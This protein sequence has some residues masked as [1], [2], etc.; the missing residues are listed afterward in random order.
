MAPMLIKR[1]GGHFVN[2]ASAGGLIPWPGA[3]C[4]ATSKYAVVGYS[5]TLRLEIAETG[6]K[7]FILCPG[8]VDTPMNDVFEEED[9]RCIP[10]REVAER[11]LAGIREGRDWIFTHAEL[12][13]FIQRNWGS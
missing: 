8:G 4:Y 5:E 6:V 7:V 2:T 3:V 12:L 10:A 9:V 11:T 13:E 1:S